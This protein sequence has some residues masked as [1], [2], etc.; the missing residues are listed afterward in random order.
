MKISPIFKKQTLI[1]KKRNLN[2]KQKNSVVKICETG[3]FTVEAAIVVP[4]VI[5]SIMATA[6]LGMILYQR[7]LMQSVAD[8]GASA[9]AASWKSLSIDMATGR[10]DNSEGDDNSLYWRLSDSDK[11][12]KLDR[13]ARYTDSVLKNREILKPLSGRVS[14]QILESALSTRLEVTVERVYGIPAGRIMGI[15]GLE[16][17]LC[18]KVTSCSGI[19]DPSEIIRN[20]GFI[21][22]IQSELEAEY[23][24]LGEVTEKIRGIFSSVKERME[25]FF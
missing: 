25:D 12:V 23:P 3:S 18:I 5:I 13:I 6:Y 17:A 11:Q 10:V 7:S 1:E 19:D 22:D 15:F 9:G 8:C 4:I 21:G 16:D 24:E 20:I 14:A 2:E